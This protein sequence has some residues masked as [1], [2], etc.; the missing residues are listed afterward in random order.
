LATPGETTTNL[1]LG[2]TYSPPGLW[3]GTPLHVHDDLDGDLGQS[4]HEEIYYHLADQVG[5]DD[6]WS[7][8]AGQFLFDNKGLNR[9]Y[10]VGHRAAFAIPG[11]AHPVVSGPNSAM[12]Y[13][14]CLAAESS[15]DLA[16]MDVPSFAWLKGVGEIVDELSASRPDSLVLKKEV[17]ELA[18]EAGLSDPQRRVLMF[19]LQQLGFT[20]GTD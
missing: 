15:H 14:W 10:V 4:D 3:S 7:A 1:I 12:M 2:E 13:V 11:A 17:E 20:L 6:G 8:Y 18:A 5:E 16:M 9:A 19:H